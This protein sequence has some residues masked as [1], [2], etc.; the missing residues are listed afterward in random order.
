M[1]TDLQRKPK[2]HRDRHTGRWILDWP[3]HDGTTHR[4]ANYRSW[5]DA[6]D[7]ALYWWKRQQQPLRIV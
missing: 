6:M 4:R 5:A 3:N 7:D 1:R 2:V